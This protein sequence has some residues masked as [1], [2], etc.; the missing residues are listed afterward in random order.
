VFLTRRLIRDGSEYLGP[1]TSV[2]QV[3]A[4]LDFIKQT[5][6][7]RTCNLALSDKNIKAGKFKACLEYHIGNCKAPCVD[8]Q[9]KEQYDVQ[10]QQVRE[11]LKGKLGSITQ[12]LKKEMTELAESMEFE[13]AELV[14]R[15]LDYI[16]N[17]QSKSII[18]SPKI[19]DVDI[20]SIVSDERYAFVNFMIIVQ[21][22]IVQTFSTSVEKKMD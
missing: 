19:D 22:S 8:F 15:K 16:K 20:C 21:G 11:L 18:V 9:S 1:Y 17:Y 3:R 10:I 12:H 4:L 5:I 13:K 7:L 14:R 2:D 6:P